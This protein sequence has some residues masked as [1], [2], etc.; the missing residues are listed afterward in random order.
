MEREEAYR[1]VKEKVKNKN[2][3]KHMLAVEA[4]MR[5]L[6][7][8][9]GEDVDSWSLAGLLHDVDYDSTADSPE[10]H[11]QVG[12][13]MLEERGVTPH[14]VDAV[15]AH[16]PHH[17]LPRVT[18]LSKALFAADPVTG[19]IV[20]AALIHPEKNLSALDVE[21]LLNRFQEKH[22]ARGANREQI[23]SCRELGLPLEEFLRLSLEAMQ[24]EADNLG[25]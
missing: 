5:R 13:T 9:L 18:P 3:V 23:M 12:A 4:V 20:A 6:A 1:L 16:N 24:E 8:E 10:R 15:R 14:I 21:F 17:G 25:L 11:S 22:F 2:L 7:E 19:L